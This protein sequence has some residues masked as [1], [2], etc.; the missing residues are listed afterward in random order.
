VFAYNKNFEE[1]D[2]D[3][4]DDDEDEDLHSLENEEDQRKFITF[5]FDFLF[6]KILEYCEDQSTN[7]IRAVANWKIKSN[8]NILKALLVNA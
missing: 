4:Y 8:E 7:R 1:V 3:E 5:T 2:G 6:K